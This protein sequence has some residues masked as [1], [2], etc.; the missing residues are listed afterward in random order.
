[1][2]KR[3]IEEIIS[4]VG[5]IKTTGT[6]EVLNIQGVSIDSRTLKE[7]NLFVPIVRIDDGHNYVE[8]AFE[9][10][11]V[12]ALWQADHVPPPEG[13]PLIIVENTLKALQN[14][15]QSYRGQLNCKVIGVTGS[16][17]K[18]TVKDI[19]TSILSTT[20]KVQKTYGNLNGEYG[21]PLSL[22]E[23]EEDTEI[24]VLEMGMSN[25]G[26]MTILSEIAKPDI[27]VITMIGVSHLSSLGSREGIALA[28]LELLQGLNSNGALIINGD[29]P[30]LTKPLSER[31]LPETL[32]V[33]RFGESHTND[34]FPLTIEINPS[35]LSFTMNRYQDKFSVRLLGRHNVLNVLAAIAVADRLQINQ[36]DIQSGLNNL[37]VTGM[38]MERIPTLKGFLIIN[39][40]WNASPVSMKAAIETVSN[41]DGFNKKVLV[42]GDML[43][44]GEKE[45]EFHEDIA[46]SIDV[47]KI[48]SVF[49]I[50]NLSR[51]ISNS[52]SN[53]K[54]EGIVKHFTSK[55]DL[56]SECNQLLNKNDV[57][58][59]K[60]SRGLKLEDICN[61]LKK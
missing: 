36:Q 45:N 30:L 12:A 19:V 35:D 26:E 18:T 15:A 42:L 14:L 43:E 57:I 50:G 48:H 16:N 38:R 32:S 60:G 40:A 37:E 7:G 53:S 10:G 23:V 51:I 8:Q 29:E 34:Y 39:D 61:S 21:L 25:A 56:V 4:M 13:L 54:I 33:I 11:A 9:N 47:T 6:S 46:K 49:T 58:L 27:G 24:V 20:Y 1:M 5:G 52:L 28:K 41:L 2:I 3:S 59:V 55:E 22:L 17:G 44:L 31:R